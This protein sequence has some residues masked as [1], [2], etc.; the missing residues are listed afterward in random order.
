MASVDFFDQ[1]SREARDIYRTLARASLDPLTL[2]PFAI[3]QEEADLLQMSPTFSLHY[4]SL[5]VGLNNFSIH[6]IKFAVAKSIG[7]I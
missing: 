4:R 7:E 3:S 2:R 6:G 5:A 1:L